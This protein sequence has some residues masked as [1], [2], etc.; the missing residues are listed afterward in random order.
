M[1]AV[2]SLSKNYGQI[3][4]LLRVSLTV[5]ESE[6]LAI[7]GR[8]GSGKTTLL[9]LIAGLE[10]PDEGCII[11]N[12]TAASKPGWVLEPYRRGLGFVF[13]TPALWPHLTVA[14]NILFGLQSLPRQEAWGR[15]QELLGQMSLKELASR[16]PHQLSGG[17]ARRVA[18]ARTLAP[19][20]RI[21]L[22]DEPLIHLDDGLKAEMLF[23]IRESVRRSEATMMY[24]AHDAREAEYLTTQI[25][26][27]DHGH[28]LPMSPID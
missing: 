10:E 19:R 22:M 27:L 8:S 11:I 26:V 25:L 28:V 3:Q 7:M 1:I 12:G 6:T 17:E 21:L 20:P 14:Q 4:A 9:R 13:Q 18:I 2:T 24:V 23:L 5:P 16:Y 15:L